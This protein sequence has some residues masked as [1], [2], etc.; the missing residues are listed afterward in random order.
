MRPNIT[1]N[2]LSRNYIVPRYDG[3]I[4]VPIDDEQTF[5]YNWMVGNDE[6]CQLDPDFVE[7]LEVGYGRGADD[8]IPGT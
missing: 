6:T 4:W 1:Q 5:I 7:N 8:Y 3:H 2:G